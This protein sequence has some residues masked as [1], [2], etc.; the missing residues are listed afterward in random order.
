VSD[1]KPT[2]IR[3]LVVRIWAYLPE[4][5]RGAAGARFRK[6]MQG[7]TDY[8]D[9]HVRLGE[10]V[11]EAPDLAWH[12]IQG[13]ATQKHSQ[14]VLNYAK[15]EN[16]RIQIEL[17]RRTLEARVRK[18]V[19]DARKTESEARTQEI[20]E[21]EA[22]L[23]LVDKL[24]R[25]GALP[26]SLPDGRMAIVKAPESFDWDDMVSERLITPEQQEKLFSLPAETS[27][28]EAQDSLSVTVAEGVSIS[29]SV[30]VAESVTVAD[31]GASNT[32][33]G[34]AHRN[35]DPASDNERSDRS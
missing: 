8:A 12:A 25:V 17:E 24:R 28:V 9:E 1:E 10:R 5:W 14:A 13:A 30:A 33:G 20:R 35:D 4:D 21:F 11:N 34:D 18:E 23:E 2:I 15:E 31:Q 7:I 26:I 32:P 6:T 3:R 19:A 22:R 29:E 27:E 16:E